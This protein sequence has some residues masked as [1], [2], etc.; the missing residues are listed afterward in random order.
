MCISV[1]RI[2]MGF[3]SSRRIRCPKREYNLPHPA[4]AITSEIIFADMSVLQSPIR[5]IDERR[6]QP[7]ARP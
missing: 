2:R 6:L 1:R 7:A 3:S 4:A 5:L